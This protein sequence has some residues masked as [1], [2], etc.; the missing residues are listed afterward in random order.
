MQPSM[1]NSLLCQKR[2]ALTGYAY[3]KSHYR[4]PDMVCSWTLKHSD[5]AVVPPPAFCPVF[6]PITHLHFAK[7]QAAAFHFSSNPGFSS[8]TRALK[9]PGGSPP[10][11]AAVQRDAG[12]LSD[13]S[14]P[15]PSPT[16]WLG[17]ASSP[18]CMNLICLATSAIVVGACQCKPIQII[19][20]IP[21]CA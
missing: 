2:Y 21:L 19:S 8:L 17:V 6:T 16:L 13:E 3:G 5:W 7:D 15:L 11:T 20:I 9:I 1:S 12:T 10:G 4:W 14:S 18:R